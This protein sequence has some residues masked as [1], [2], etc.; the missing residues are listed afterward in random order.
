MHREKLVEMSSKSIEGRNE[1]HRYVA[2]E[3]RNVIEVL[4]DFGSI[5]NV[6]LEYFI[7]AAGFIKPREFSIASAPGTQNNLEM[8][9]SLVNHTTQMKRKIKGMCT[10]YLAGLRSGDSLRAF[11]KPGRLPLPPKEAPLIL[12]ATGTGLAPHKSLLYHRIHNNSC[13][14]T[15]FF[16]CRHPDYD[17]ICKDELANMEISKKLIIYTAFSQQ[18]HNKIYVQN[19]MRAE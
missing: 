14:N 19:R 6:P 7:E 13:D 11:V 18:G 10:H 17:Y 12:V 2:K 8:L 9:V 1:Y 15:L 3:K 16:G 5:R 4:W